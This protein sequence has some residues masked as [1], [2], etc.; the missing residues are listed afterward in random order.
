MLL[1]VHRWLRLG[2]VVVILA[3]AVLWIGN[4]G[5]SAPVPE[6]GERSISTPVGAASTA[7]LAAAPSVEAPPAATAA[8]AAATTPVP[9]A[10]A[11]IAS[12][13]TPP[14]PAL[15]QLAAPVVPT[16]FVVLAGTPETITWRG[17]A[18]TA[19][20]C[21]WSLDLASWSG[22]PVSTV[23]GDGIARCTVTPQQTAFYR[24][25]FLGLGTYGQI[26]RGVV[27][28]NPGWAGYVAAGGPFSLVT[29]TLTVPTIRPSTTRSDVATWVGI[30][31]T[32]GDQLI[33]AGAWETYDPATGQTP[34]VYAWWE[35]WPPLPAQRVAL[36]V[37]EGDTLTVSIWREASE[38]WTIEIVNDTQGL[39]ASAETDY[40]G[41]ASSAEWIVEAPIDLTTGA[42][43]PLADFKPPVSFSRIGFTGSDTS[44]LALWMYDLTTGT[45]RTVPSA[46]SSDGRGFTVTD[47]GA[48]S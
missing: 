16:Y 8:A 21:Q 5:L 41:A 33:Q 6:S 35:V 44:T 22:F 48:G 27:T 36:P 29:G 37:S 43:L 34:D 1:S 31:G 25:Y 23:S 9:P 11:P 7:P 3:F 14:P 26:V 12:I 46:L 32:G 28:Q 30:G 4:R 24:P 40:T 10:L 19:F 42:Q 20:Q 38:R 13:P 47:L 18:G 17:V 15:G 45:K 39:A 2:V